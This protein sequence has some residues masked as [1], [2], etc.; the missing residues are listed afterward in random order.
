MIAPTIITEVSDLYTDLEKPL[1]N[2]L[3]VSS[4]NTIIIIDPYLKYLIPN[5][6]TVYNKPGVAKP[7]V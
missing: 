3:S 2:T 5:N 4:I 1:V 6:I 7:L